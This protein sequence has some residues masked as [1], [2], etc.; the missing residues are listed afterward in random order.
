MSP[1]II[2]IESVSLPKE[3]RPFRHDDRFVAY[4]RGG[5][6]SDPMPHGDAVRTACGL[7]YSCVGFLA[8]EPVATPVT[9]DYSKALPGIISRR[10]SK[11]T[12]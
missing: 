5:P 11:T 4:E 8:D 2:E 7:T 10:K 6:I 3:M 9:V 1:N 12:S